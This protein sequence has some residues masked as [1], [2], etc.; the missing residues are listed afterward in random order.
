MSVSDVVL[1]AVD[2]A[3][4]AAE[5]SE[6]ESDDNGSFGSGFAGLVDTNTLV[7]EPLIE[8][9]VASGGDSSLWTNGEADGEENCPADNPACKDGQ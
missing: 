3:A 7:T 6:S 5:E 2:E 4:A 9:P 8:E 1:G